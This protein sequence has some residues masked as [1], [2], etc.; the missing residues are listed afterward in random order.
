MNLNGVLR[1]KTTAQ[2]FLFTSQRMT[3]RASRATVL[4]FILFAFPG[5]E[6]CFCTPVEQTDSVPD[7]RQLLQKMADFSPDPCGPPYGQEKDRHSEN[8]EIRLFD[9]AQ[10]VIAQ[11]L[12]ASAESSLPPRARAEEALKKLAGMSA[13]VNAAWPE[14]NRFH[15]QILELPPALVVKMG[16]RTHETFFVFGISKEASGKPNRLWEDV[17][18]GDTSAER[19]VPQLSLDIYPLHRG[20]SGN[21][22]FLARFDISGCAGPTGVEYDVHE[23]NPGGYGYLEQI[24]KQDGSFGLSEVPEFAQIGEFRTE[25]SIITLPF[26][27]YSAI[28]TWDNPSLCAVDTYDLSGD[29]VQFRSRSHN[30]PDLVPIAKAIEYAEKRDYPA[31]RAYCASANVAHRLIRENPPHAEAILQTKRTGKYRER[32]EIGE[33]FFDVEKRA[34]RWLVVGFG[35]E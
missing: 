35:A 24:I 17:G 29:N 22:R 27:S 34:G 25:G 21:V 1:P 13:E 12:N 31:V 11:E 5:A 7:F 2:V 3:L 16:I 18:S 32:I 4:S 15:F 8:V 6:Q 23:W 33:Y 10:Q 20:P 30:R 9:Q 19:S 28:D 14:E 26:C